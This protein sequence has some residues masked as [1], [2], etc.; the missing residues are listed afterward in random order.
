[1]PYIIT[2]T[3]VGKSTRYVDGKTPFRNPHKSPTEKNLAMQF[4]TKDDAQRIMDV[5]LYSLSMS[6]DSKIFQIEELQ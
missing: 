1:M 6:K 4:P 3:P 2:F 5:F